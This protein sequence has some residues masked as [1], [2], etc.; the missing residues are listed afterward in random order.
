[1]RVTSGTA[2]STGE[3]LADG[4]NDDAVDVGLDAGA[5]V[6][7]VAA[8]GSIA[9]VRVSGGARSLA[10]WQGPW[11]HPKQLTLYASNDTVRALPGSPG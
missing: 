4:G 8:D 9:S 10:F 11:A 5:E 1:M 3:V 2:P 6:R 7:L